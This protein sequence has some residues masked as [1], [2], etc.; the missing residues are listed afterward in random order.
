MSKRALV[1]SGG[2]SRGAYQ[3]GAVKALF[4]KGIYHDLLFGTSVGAL[5]AAFLSMY[6]KDDPKAISE[7]EKIWTEE[8][9][10]ANDVYCAAFNLP[11]IKYVANATRLLFGLPAF[12]VSPLERLLK[13]KVD[14]AKWRNGR[15]FFWNAV[16][17]RT[18]ESVIFTNVLEDQDATEI[19][20][21][22][23]VNAV[24]A[25]AAI[26]LVFEKRR[27]VSK[28]RGSEEYVDG[29]LRDMAIVSKA[30]RA[31]ADSIDT[32]TCY[33]TKSLPVSGR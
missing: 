33:N 27:V 25:S 11:I 20:D 10:S 30:L 21:D 15:P 1:L 22:Q 8:I 19:S 29:G 23:I 5:N 3:V 18:L 16:E 17:L 14:V 28:E 7:L 24:L 31:G 12:S 9:R 2:A 32:V 4:E 13:R 6:E 26:P